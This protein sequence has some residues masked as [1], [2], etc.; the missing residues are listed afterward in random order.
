MEAQM[1]SR[2]LTEQ[3]Y[4]LLAQ[5]QPRAALAMFEQAVGG[6]EKNIRAWQGKGL[7]L[8]HMGKHEEAETA[9]KRALE[10]Q[11]GAVAVTNN[12]AMSKILHGQYQ[13]AIN[14]LTPLSKNKVPISTVVE[15][16]AL[17]NCLLGKSDEARKLYG[18]NLLPAEIEENLRFCRQFEGMRKK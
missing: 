1:S 7:A 9:Y 15:N 6:N 2:K 4:E 17:A 5:Q 13:E 10:I 12:L 18:K 16:L 11:P 3:G 8:N 14:L